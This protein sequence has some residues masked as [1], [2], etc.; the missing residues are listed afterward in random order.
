MGVEACHHE[1]M[2]IV[3]SFCLSR[4]MTLVIVG[5]TFDWK[6]NIVPFVIVLPSPQ[7]TTL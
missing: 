2:K 5:V 6:T 7:R 1:G 4:D 3:D